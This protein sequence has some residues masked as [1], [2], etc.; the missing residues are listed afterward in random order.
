MT[1]QL[2]KCAHIVL[3][4]KIHKK[5]VDL[6]ACKQLFMLNSYKSVIKKIGNK[7]I[8]NQLFFWRDLNQTNMSALNLKVYIMLFQCIEFTNIIYLHLE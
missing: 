1:T 5:F 6:D 8:I 2:H 7:K 3:L 4:Y